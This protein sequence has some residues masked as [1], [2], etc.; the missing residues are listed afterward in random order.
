M[1]ASISLPVAKAN[2]D[3]KGPKMMY[4]CK[5]LTGEYTA[6]KGVKRVPPHKPGN[7][8][9]ILFDSVVDDT[10]DPKIFVIFN[11]TQAYPSYLITFK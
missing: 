4:L 7:Q 10:K 1:D 3:D 6:G 5:V 8:N 11:D 9:Y 2:A